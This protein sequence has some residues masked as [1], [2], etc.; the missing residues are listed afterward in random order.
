MATM[1]STRAAPPDAAGNLG[2]FSRPP[3]VVMTPSPGETGESPPPM[4]HNAVGNTPQQRSLG[5]LIAGVV[6]VALLLFS[7][8]LAFGPTLGF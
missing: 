8:L 7:A 3:D 6:L 4:H 2:A 1:A 5:A